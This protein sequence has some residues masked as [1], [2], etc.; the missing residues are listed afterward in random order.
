MCYLRSVSRPI[1]VVFAS[2]ERHV[3][4]HKACVQMNAIFDVACL[5]SRGVG[6]EIG[7]LTGYEVDGMV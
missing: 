2:C 7:V 3:V 6:E 4:A 1:S 5:M